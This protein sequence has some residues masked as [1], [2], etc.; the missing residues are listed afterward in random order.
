MNAVVLHRHRQQLRIERHLRD[1]VDRHAVAALAGHRAQHVETARH[2][3]EHATAELVV[4]LACVVATVPSAPTCVG[5]PGPPSPVPPGFVTARGHRE[6][7]APNPGGDGTARC[8][9]SSC[10]GESVDQA[11]R[12]VGAVHAA[13]G[14]ALRPC[15]TTLVSTVRLIT[16][17]A[18][19]ASLPVSASDTTSANTTEARPRGPNH[20]MNAIV[21]RSS[22][23]RTST[24]ANRE[25]PHHRER[26]RRE[27][28]RLPR[29]ESS[30]VHEERAEHEPHDEREQRAHA[31]VELQYL[32]ALAGLEDR[33]ERETA[34]ERGDEPVDPELVGRPRTRATRTRRP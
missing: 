32:V 19:S 11:P 3:P 9:T 18:S 12:H 10:S 1:P 4:L 29:D 26:E 2:L 27:H 30:A 24:S 16:D 21:E 8:G 34:D 14:F 17:N 20:P 22:P 28:E 23:E 5:I 7:V 15:A 6:P 25:H 31:R 33:A 13:N